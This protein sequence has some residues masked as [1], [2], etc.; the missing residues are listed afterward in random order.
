MVA[1]THTVQAPTISTG[2]EKACFLLPPSGHFLEI[3]PLPEVNG[4]FVT[5]PEHPSTG[6]LPARRP[7]TAA[8]CL[9]DRPR[10]QLSLSV[11]G[12][13]SRIFRDSWSAVMNK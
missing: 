5:P 4:S 1:P 10:E 7:P 9:A 8:F 11:L 13:K 6:M 12:T 2:E 3:P